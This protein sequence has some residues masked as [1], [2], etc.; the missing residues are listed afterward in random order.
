MQQFAKLS[1]LERFLLIE[2]AIFIIVAVMALVARFDYSTLLALVGAVI[3]TFSFVGR[4]GHA[5][6]PSPYNSL[7]VIGAV[8]LAASA[9]L[10]FF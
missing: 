3:L 9:I 8:P 5:A 6:D 7:V 1:P 2:G 10:A 4:R